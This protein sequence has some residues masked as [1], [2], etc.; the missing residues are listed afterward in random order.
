ME[1]PSEKGGAMR[2]RVPRAGS[3]ALLVCSLL[4]LTI[5]SLSAQGQSPPRK[6]RGI[7]MQSF[8]PLD[9]RFLPG[10]D[11]V[12]I[13]MGLVC[14]VVTDQPPTLE[15]H[16]AELLA[17]GDLVAIVRPFAIEVTPDV[18]SGWLRTHV[19]ASIDEVLWR[20]PFV[21]IDVEEGD[22]LS[23]STHGGVLQMGTVTV[24]TTHYVTVHPL[25]PY[26]VSV[27]KEAGTTEL[28]TTPTPLRI[29]KGVLMS[30]R[31][32]T[33]VPDPLGGHSLTKIRTLL[34][35]HAELRL[36]LGFD[37]PE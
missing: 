8:V 34:A 16:A 17:S 7:P 29:S 20:D 12:E 18:E 31:A 9:G 6:V 32:G 10:D 35:E 23:F 19:I 36:R 2:Y 27:R 3:V 14:P 13:E 24:R 11:I 33:Y 25:E 5:P 26:L 22:N 28:S 4:L 1:S 21:A 37:V 30:A 15:D